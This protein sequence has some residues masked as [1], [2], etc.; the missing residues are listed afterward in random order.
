MLIP[1]DYLPNAGGAPTQIARVPITCHE[2]MFAQYLPIKMAGRS[3]IRI[4][5]NLKCFAPLVVLSFPDIEDHHYVY[6]T[7]KYLYVEKDH[8]FNRPGWHIDGFGSDDINYVWCD[9][10]PTEFCEQDF[11]LSQDHE[12]SMLD[13][14]RTARAENI[15]TYPDNTLLRL[16]NK[17]V[18]RVPPVIEPGMRTFCKISISKDRYNLEGNA[19]NYLFD[20]DWPMVPRAPSRNHP[21]AKA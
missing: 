17:I 15:R 6:L 4:P 13:M 2:M 11:Y 14:Q 19:H 1:D 9:R 8:C 20:Y 21:S 16:T 7:A 3:Y 5:P 18:H 12:I 10:G